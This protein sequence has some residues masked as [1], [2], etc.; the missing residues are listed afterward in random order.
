[1]TEEEKKRLLLEKV[2]ARKK[3]VVMEKPKRPE[4][5]HHKRDSFPLSD[6][7]RGIWMD[8][9]LE[10]DSAV[11]NIPFAC[12]IRGAVDQEVLKQSLQR[13]LDRNDAWR[14]VIVKEGDETVQKVCESA[15]LDYRWFDLRKNDETDV[16]IAEK[17]KEFVKEP[18]DLEKGPLVRFALYQ[19]EDKV[20]YFILSAHHI[21]YDGSSENI[22]CRELSREYNAILNGE[23]SSL[24]KPTISYGDYA[25]Y[26]AELERS[27]AIQ[28]Q[29]RYWTEELS[30]VETVEFPT[31]KI[32]PSVRH[33]EGGM[34]YFS[35]EESVEKAVYE[36]ARKHHFT[37]NVI[38]F[39][40][41][42]CLLHLY[43]RSNAVVI[44][45][46]V[47]DRE[48]ERIEGLIG[49]F[50]NNLVI[51][52]EVTD[53]MSF[54]E[55]VAKTMTKL[56][57]AYDNKDVP[58]ERLVEAVQP[59]RDLSRTAFYQVGFTYNPRSRM[60]LV[61]QGCECEEF[62]LGDHL[63][64]TDV[65]FQIHD[66]ENSIGGFVEYN[67][68]IYNRDT[69]FRILQNY[70][71]LLTRFIESSARPIGE[72][73]VVT[74][75]EKQTILTEFNDTKVEYSAEKTIVNLFEEQVG[76]TPDETAIVFEDRSLSYAQLNE[77]AN[78]LA[79]RLRNLGMKPD[80]FAVI[81]AERSPEM[82]V[83]M[84]GVLKAGGAYVPV[85]PEYPEER[86]RYMIEDCHPKVILTYG[87]GVSA[88]EWPEI[89]TIRLE[90]VAHFPNA[91]ENPAPVA[92]PH[93]LA[94][95]I[96]T[97]GTTG[98]PKGV[99]IQHR[100]VVNYVSRSEKSVM[101]YAFRQNLKRFVSVTNMIFDIFV[102]EVILTLCNGLTAYI[103]NRE[104]QNDLQ[105]F[106]QLIKE[107]DIQILQT[108]PSRIKGMFAQDPETKVFSG[109]RYIMLGGEAVGADVVRKLKESSGAL[110]ENV[111]GP[112]ETTV[113]STC[114]SIEEDYQNIPVGY[115]IANTQVYIVQGE[116]MC[117]IGI[118]GELCI[119]GDGL[120]R[121][122]LNKQ[123]LTAAKF[124]KNP[125]GEGRMYH[126]GDLARWLPDG[127]IEYLGRIDDQVKVRGFRIELGEIESRTRELSFI[128]D[129]AVLVREDRSG[130]KAIHAYLVGDGK[131]DLSEVRDALARVLPDYMIPTHMMQIESI[132]VTKNGKLD[133]RALPE[134]EVQT[135]RE[136]VAPT[137]ET[138]KEICDIFS[139][140]LG[141]AQVS[142]EDEF[143][144]LGGHSLKATK[145]VN[146][147]EETT[148]IRIPLREIFKNA[149]PRALARRIDESYR[150]T[151]QTAAACIAKA[152]EKPEYPMSSAQKRM[153]LLYQLESGGITYNIPM[154]YEV[155][156]RLDPARV[157][158]SF[159]KMLSRHE[160]LRTRLLMKGDELVQQV[161][162][163]VPAD[164]PEMDLNGVD[165]SGVEAAFDSFVKA[166]DL[167]NPPLVRMAIAH[168][169]EKDLLFLD[170]HHSVSDAYSLQLFL[171]EFT[172]IY[173]GETLPEPEL[174]YKDYSE[175]SK[176]REYTTEREYWMDQF[177]DEIPV[178]D[179]PT[180]F[181]R[182]QEQSFSGD[183]CRTEI[184]ASLKEAIGELCRKT[185]TTEYMVLLAGVM[186]TL[187]K[188]SHQDD[189]VIGS[190]ISGRTHAA[191]E[192]MMGMFINSLAMRGKPSPQKSF[193]AFLQEIRE[194]ALRAYENQEYPFEKLVEDIDVKRNI[195]RNPIFDVLFNFQK[196][197][198]AGMELDGKKVE[199]VSIGKHTVAKLDLNFTIWEQGEGYEFGLEYCTAL[200]SEET[201]VSILRNCKNILAQAVKT[202]D[203]KIGELEL[204]TPAEKAEIL[205]RVAENVLEYDDVVC[206]HTL[207]EE[208][209]RKTP[210]AT[211]VCYEKEHV[212]YRE[213]NER[214]NRLAQL[215]RAEGLQ[216][217]DRVAIL[218]EKSVA[219]LTAVFGVLKAGG[220]Y[221]PL[222]T[223][224][225]MDRICSILERSKC[226]VL[227]TN[228]E[229]DQEIPLSDGIRKI[230]LDEC[231]EAMESMPAGNPNLPI[232]PEQLMYVIFTSGST[233]VPKGVAVRHR[234][235]F[236]Y[237]RGIRKELNV[238]E[239][240]S[241]ALVST[242]AAD[243]G[244]T[245]IFVPLVTGGCVH[246]VSY[247]RATDP[248]AL[249]Q[250]FSENEIDAMK[251]VPSHFEAMQ[252]LE[253]PET[254]L[255][256][257][258]II[259][260]G[261]AC[262][263][264]VVGKIR[265]QNPDCEIYNNY[266]PTETT[267]SV[268]CHKVTEEVRAGSIV[269]LGKPIDGV[270][271][272]VLDEN[273]QLLPY[274]VYGELYIGGPTVSAG[275][276]GDPEGTAKAFIDNPFAPD[277]PYKIYRTGDKVRLLR[278]GDIDMLGRMDRQIKIRGYRIDPEGVE[279][280]LCRREE[281]RNAVVMMRKDRQG[282]A[283]L[284]AYLVPAGDVGTVDISEIR[285]FL[286]G[287]LPEYMV[288]SVFMIIDAVPITENGK[289]D[290]RK[291][292]DIQ[293][294]CVEVREEYVAPRNET[295][296]R[297]VIVFK[298]VLGLERVGIDDNFFD[299]GGES[300]KSIK[301]V[302]R[303]DPTLNV[304]QLFKHPT[305]RELAKIIGG[306][307]P[308][309]Q[310][311]ILFEL[312]RPDGK[313]RKAN[314]VCIPYGGGNAITYQPLAN[315]MPEGYG[316]YSVQVPGHD[317]R[318]AVPDPKPL[319][320]VAQMCVD[321]I[322]KKVKG[323]IAIYGQCV[324]GALAVL[325]AMLLEKEG[326]E[327]IGVFEA[328]HFPYPRLP[329][330]FFEFWNKLIPTESL[331]SNRLYRESLKMIGGGDESEDE[332]EQEYMIKG[333]RH[334]MR[335]AEDFYT[336]ILNYTPDFQK[337]RSPICCI[338]GERDRETMF[339]QE[340]YLEWK[341]FSDTVTL[342][343]IPQ[344]GHFFHKHQ[345]AE[346]AALMT[347][348][349]VEWQEEKAK[350]KDLP[351][352]AQ[353]AT[354][355]KDKNSL[356]ALR[357]N[358][359]PNLKIMAIVALGQIVS[360]LGSSMSS[361][362]M[363]IWAM[364]DDINLGPFAII[365]I[366]IMVTGLVVAPFAGP[367]V[368]RFDRRK[369]MIISDCIAAV[370]TVLV[371]TMLFF[372][373][374]QM[375]Q[376]YLAAI[377]SAFAGA[378]QQPAYLA[379][380][381]QIAPKRYLGH[382]NG[383]IQLGDSA[384]RFL[385]PM[386]GGAMLALFDLKGVLLIDFST[387]LISIITLSLVRFPNSMFRKREESFKKE[388]LG[389]WKYIAKRKSMR[390]MVIFFVVV[391][392]FGY[393]AAFLEQPI[394]RGFIDKGGMGVV[395]AMNSIGMIIGAAIITVWGGFSRR[396]KG[397]IGF[398]M[399][400]GLAYMVFALRPSAWLAAVGMFGV[401]LSLSI[402]N[403]HWQILI[404]TK[405]GMELQGRV[406]SINVMLVS[407]LSPFS[408]LL[409]QG[410]SD[411]YFKDL[412][413]KTGAAADFV[414]SVLGSD[415][416]R[417]MALLCLLFGLCMFICGILGMKWKTLLYME[418][419]LPDAVPGAVIYEDKDKIQD[420]L[421]SEL[422]QAG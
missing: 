11:Y 37:P 194:T 238:S 184:D 5:V 247:E 163:S 45:T 120:A 137:T 276:L 340:R 31:D 109:M 144:R 401:G 49:C 219:A 190:P 20:F 187:G 162:D 125:Y 52:N 329:G 142:A 141:I 214:A 215:L 318:S 384:S 368:D 347:E 370:G 397:M 183:S 311:G 57:T 394:L 344:T 258:K 8:Y 262:K 272:Y 366:L 97:S 388:L 279:E 204:I 198:A 316:L 323:P 306:D 127:K 385:A 260:A 393:A 24:A 7:Q 364:G 80:D 331:T 19:T 356:K 176:G 357:E 335:E 285:T 373:E 96:Y 417:G 281:I 44:G 199:Y 297:I 74:D 129:C 296:E 132:P 180:D 248:E 403:A 201:A 257:K 282:D 42:S 243:L 376:V 387:F 346:L 178:L 392:F 369:V 386:L 58:L 231:R 287:V 2:S 195:S 348:Q 220:T 63:T 119:A 265:N 124:V 246:M 349:V 36:Y 48:D 33:T 358:P 179:L 1:M 62:G 87:E 82:I 379:A 168:R 53:G 359:R 128:K 16:S 71:L 355:P 193:T 252:V 317:F 291:L 330:R 126:T 395:L 43:S 73:E 389:G 304:L 240:M 266:G 111:Y 118:P 314:F 269:P 159:A 416:A 332:E 90:D 81:M 170:M 14:C 213:L 28:E 422:K 288:P 232:S 171:R 242:F 235:Y 22:F 196:N 35:F 286:R 65:N 228:N 158:S 378:F 131:I 277:D 130:E 69:I 59:P 290:Y 270:R 263:Y 173:N 29:L 157:R 310:E 98:N 339:Y 79:Y 12:K 315:A 99:M 34:L 175:Y 191:T 206:I 182:P 160:I 241:F 138:E 383:V 197:E 165:E 320:E 143:F 396:A 94:Y 139:E 156:G 107:N 172:A 46:T 321:E 273:R 302:R 209:V 85:D 261:E 56:F 402:L 405:V 412:P 72:I 239:P 155:D 123:E 167:G 202:P 154:A 319:E 292:P 414:T 91:A 255:P 404:Q 55:I 153:F 377:L 410:L 382:V 114:L 54:D 146:K 133:R 413:N 152:E 105:R 268:L 27:S 136:Y 166:F 93:N 398:V 313:E 70:Q 250:Y 233:G 353:P 334:D 230:D 78:R 6:V 185:G 337:I 203:A 147:I 121:G 38:L 256:G 208:Q 104:Q 60:E 117:G 17:A 226:T 108:T 140:V 164:V 84:Y 229:S 236:Y 151:R 149:T 217:E 322:K 227:I 102:T 50:I 207:F 222:D 75:S 211:A 380:I 161:V 225:P 361:Y 218:L 408:V 374:I 174:Q 26:R 341:D 115:P 88:G 295:E 298:D 362:A 150:D 407:L 375:W 3:Q 418:D 352:K 181:P 101:A 259:L 64:F 15:N 148:G 110:V 251:F 371:A 420:Q 41:M 363:G 308:K 89:T 67:S 307:A 391:N 264:E 415:P 186:V 367:I 234:N 39:A 333:M 421:D 381:A 293:D 350:Q 336:E 343:H 267:V 135:G 328:A 345:S 327:V 390:A 294:V 254:V 249:S 113:W 76:R 326:A 406:F 205:S 372:G 192:H 83:G 221:V 210:E 275:Y 283:R 399:P 86:I 245:N 325:L 289:L 188:Y 100:N 9:L 278:N 61:L 23:E 32:R 112:S 13:I 189:I 134:I 400:W 10:S 338:F 312:T 271:A 409:A 200:F 30:G 351:V 77:N 284:A 68:S 21:V 116:T 169:G 216:E 4:L 18:I 253:H 300:F 244:S 92:E 411:V 106:E 177:R 122:Y 309:E 47:A 51:V 145:V 301:A 237:L 360:L 95:C 223:H 419:V 342:R 224:Y 303:I 280:V 305:A 25:I 365:S 354:K 103:A 212:S 66:D 40:G 274:G 299:L 324:G